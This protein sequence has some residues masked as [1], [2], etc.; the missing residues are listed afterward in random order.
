MVQLLEGPV[1]E[2]FECAENAKSAIPLL[3]RGDDFPAFLLQD[4][5]R[6]LKRQHASSVLKKATCASAPEVHATTMPVEGGTEVLSKLQVIFPMHI[7]VEA[8]KDKRIIKLH[9]QHQYVAENLETTDK[10]KVTQT[11]AVIRQNKS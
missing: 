9:I 1:A 10:R 6:E 5:E 7:E 2:G 3:G 11:F 4:V 8:G